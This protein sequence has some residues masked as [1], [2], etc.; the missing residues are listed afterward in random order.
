[1]AKDSCEAHV[2]FQVEDLAVASPATVSRCGMVY[3]EP[4]LPGFPAPDE[5]E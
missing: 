5:E 4:T 2:A 3:Q 1:M